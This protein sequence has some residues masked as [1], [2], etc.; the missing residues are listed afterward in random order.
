MAFYNLY[1]P[2]DENASSTPAQTANTQVSTGTTATPTT[3]A[4]PALAYGN[5]LNLPVL[6]RSQRRLLT[7]TGGQYIGYDGQVHTLAAGTRYGDIRKAFYEERRA[8][9][10]YQQALQDQELAKTMGLTYNGGM[11]KFVS[12]D[13]RKIYEAGLN[14][15]D[16]SYMT[17]EEVKPTAPAT[18]AP[19]ATAT[20]TPQPAASADIVY[21][22]FG[23]G[24]KWDARNEAFL[25]A[26]ANSDKFNSFVGDNNTIGIDQ[27]KA[28]QTANGLVADGKIGF[29]SLTKAKEL[30]LINEKDFG[31][32]SAVVKPTVKPT[33]STGGEIPKGFLENPKEF[34]E[35]AGRTS[36]RK[37]GGEMKYFQ[38]GGAVNAQQAA[39]DQAQAQQEQLNEIFMAIAKNPKETLQALAQQGVQP[40]QIIEIAQKMSESNPAAREALSAMQKMSQM[41]KQGA[42]LQYF[43]RL[44][45]ECPEGYEMK[46]FKSGGVICSK[47]MKKAEALQNGGTPKK[48]D[49]PESVAK[50][51]EMR[52]GGKA[53]KK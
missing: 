39:A 13:A 31:T 20:T 41:A 24:N 23:G 53:K 37:K 21:N 25:K 32:L 6:N 7:K 5:Y 3:P 19:A 1:T 15:P 38:A 4:K 28:W 51:K 42:K 46:M 16:K 17:Y 34:F 30:G 11:P 14:S 44:R 9:R 26:A 49:E 2:D 10:A 22:G 47:C 50:F 18:T 12:E 27:L 48:S 33:V 35:S 40:K 29:N 36:Y 8:R 43:K 45:G 52:C